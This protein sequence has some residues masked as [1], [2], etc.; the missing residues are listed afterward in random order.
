ME[1]S[2]HQRRGEHPG[3]DTGGRRAPK[4]GGF[5]LT[6][7]TEPRS[8]ATATTTQDT[9]RRTYKDYCATPDDE[10]Y[11]LLNGNLM[12]VPAPNRKHQEV[13]GTLYLELGNFAKEHELGRVYVAPFDVVLSDTD[14]VQ[15]DLLFISRARE[16]TLTE[17]NVRGAPDLV[18]EILS[19]STAER[20]L[21]YKHELYGRHGVLRSTGSSIRWRDHRRASQRD[22][23]L[24]LAETFE[25]RDT[26]RTAVLDGF[27]AE[28]GRHPLRAEESRH[29]KNHRDGPHRR[30][31]A[32]GRRCASLDW[33]PT[34]AAE[35]PA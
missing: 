35:P 26:L 1:P 7:G 33:A 13:L 32:R 14:I 25:R 16:H 2:H 34:K 18:I 22:G 21:G 11:E 15:P 20:D 24:E 29:G 6:S 4:K 19:P 30:R 3:S 17:E 31:R 28:A 12:M 10:R 9:V 5:H 23:R 8:T 27:A